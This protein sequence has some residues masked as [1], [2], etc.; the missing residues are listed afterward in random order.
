[1][2]VIEIVIYGFGHI[3][4]YLTEFLNDLKGWFIQLAYEQSN[5]NILVNIRQSPYLHKSKMAAA[6]AKKN[7]FI[8]IS[9][10]KYNFNVML[11]F[12]RVADYCHAIL[13][14]TN[15]EVTT[16]AKPHNHPSDKTAGRL[17]QQLSLTCGSQSP[18]HLETN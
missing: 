17:E 16:L 10:S 11:G 1:M 8:H 5:K 9:T 13:K 18:K 4:T 7:Y 2:A 6:E 14:T 15:D 12:R 3:S